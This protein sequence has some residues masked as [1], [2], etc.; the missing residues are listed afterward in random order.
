ML[1]LARH[2]SFL[3][4]SFC[5]WRVMQGRRCWSLV[6]ISSILFLAWNHGSNDHTAHHVSLQMCHYWF[7]MSRKFNVTLYFYC[8]CLAHKGL[9]Q[10]RQKR[11]SAE[12]FLMSTF[13]I[14]LVK[15]LNWTELN[16]FTQL[17]GQG[18]GTTVTISLFKF[19]LGRPRFWMQ[20]TMPYF[21][22]IHA[23]LWTCSVL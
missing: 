16:P 14:Q 13:M 18:E 3:R 12:S 10:I 21:L 7:H 9:L 2:D 8:S 5:Y 20:F 1:V 15:G 17:Y 11:I 4:H 22:N 6:T 19:R 23:Y